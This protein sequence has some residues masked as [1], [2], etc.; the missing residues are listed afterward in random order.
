MSDEEIRR[1]ER[2]LAPDPSDAIALE[3]LAAALSRARRGWY[4]EPLPA[5][6]VPS[7]KE[8]NVYLYYRNILCLEM[9][10]I[11]GDKGTSVWT[12]T[13]QDGTM[14]AH[15]AFY[16]SRHPVTRGEWMA[17]GLS[18]QLGSE[19]DD[20]YYWSRE[21]KNHPVTHVSHEDAQK[22][23]DKIDLRLPAWDEFVRA[24]GYDLTEAGF[25]VVLTGKH[26]STS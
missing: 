16:I 5:D 26:S 15:S 23:C 3:R 14:R 1:L 4:G 24:T 11:P 12:T 22:F 19:T 25:R 2:A 9:V 21:R 10:Y 13:N 7:P 17:S 20:N 8:R 18:C 6:L